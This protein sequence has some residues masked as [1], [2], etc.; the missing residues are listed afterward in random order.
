MP[1]PHPSGPAANS[2]KMKFVA[3]AG[4]TSMHFWSAWLAFGH[5][6]ACHTRPRSSPA[7]AALSSLLRASRI[8]A[9]KALLPSALLSAAP[10]PASAAPLAASPA[11]S[12]AARAPAGRSRNRASGLLCSSS[13]SSSRRS[14]EP[15]DSQLPRRNAPGPGDAVEAADAQLPRRA[16]PS[17]S[18][19]TTTGSH[20]TT[21][22]AAAPGCG[23]HAGPAG[24][25]APGPPRNAIGTG[26]AAM[27]LTDLLGG[28]WEAAPAVRALS[29]S[30]GSLDDKAA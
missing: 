12:A 16:T 25:N 8:A 3:C 17:F 18:G 5:L 13:A 30:L 24:T 22:A 29:S 11:G 9:W 6:I 15:A 4:R 21:D 14:A 2:S 10:R 1:P 28:R 19:R 26:C 23:W 7:S 20:M 27:A